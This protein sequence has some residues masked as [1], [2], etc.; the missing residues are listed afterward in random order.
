MLETLYPQWRRFW[1][2]CHPVGRASAHARLFQAFDHFVFLVR[3]AGIGCFGGF[4]PLGVVLLV[5][6]PVGKKASARDF[7]IFVLPLFNFPGLGGWGKW[8][9]DVSRTSGTAL[10]I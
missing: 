8:V 2:A 3:G 4:L 9:V 6:M 1:Y 5:C 10:L 7:C